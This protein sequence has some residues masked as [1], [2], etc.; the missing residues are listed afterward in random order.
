MVDKPYAPIDKTILDEAYALVSG[1]RQDSY[2]HP[3]DN[4]RRI[5]SI[6]SGILDMD[7][8]EAQVGLC[9]A[10]MKLAREGFKHQRDNLVDAV[11]YI[12]TTDAVVQTFNNIDKQ[13]N[14]YE[15]TAPSLRGLEPYPGNDAVQ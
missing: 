5:A 6:W 13:V 11:G 3:V 2:S 14:D 7:V 1:G 4:F 10:G 9:M 12:L 15:R 8:S